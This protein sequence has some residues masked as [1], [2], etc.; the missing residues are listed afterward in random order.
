VKVVENQEVSGTHR[1]QPVHQIS[2][3]ETGASRDQ[4]FHCFQYIMRPVNTNLGSAGNTL[5]AAERLLANWEFL[6]K[7]FLDKGRPREVNFTW[8]RLRSGF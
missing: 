4:N 2:T 8:F 6:Y 3:Y 7:F 5:E 1:G